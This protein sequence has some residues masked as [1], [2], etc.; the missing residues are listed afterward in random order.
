MPSVPSDTTVWDGPE[1][2]RPLLVPIDTLVPLQGNPRRGDVEAVVRSLTEFGQLKPVTHRSS[3]MTVTAGNHT[4]LAALSLGWTHLASVPTDHDETRSK[5]WAV[6]DNRTS[7][8]AVNDDEDLAAML[9]EIAAADAELLHAASYTDTDLADLLKSLEPPFVPKTDPDAVP[10]PP[11]VPVTQ[12]GDVWVLGDHR[13][14]CG[15][16]TD[17]A[18]V[19]RVLDGALAD[20]TWTDPPYGVDY[21]G[22]TADKLTIDGDTADGLYDLL[23]GAFKA[24]LDG[25]RPGSPWYLA[26]PPGP[27]GT[28]FRLAV[29]AAGLNLHQVLVWVKDQFVLGHSDYHYRHEDILYGFTPGPGRSG[30]GNHEGTRWLGDH[31]SDSVFEVPRP[32]RS[33]SHPTMKPTA[34]IA[35]MITNSCPPGGVVFDGFAGSGSTLAAALTVDRRAALIE[36]SPTY[37]DVIVARWEAITAGKAERG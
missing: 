9:Q 21:V 16:C 37:C 27:R 1:Q 4:R 25:L 22:K 36:L 31:A 12:L 32:R 6:A 17:P 5:A 18:V 20:M 30:R 29:D 8:L 24:M 28:T 26:A 35:A 14:V 13:L 34:L 19:T 33:E 3:D 10:D 7:D 2:L 11:V 23:L 15:D